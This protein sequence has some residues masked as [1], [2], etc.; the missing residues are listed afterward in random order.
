M[1]DGKATL[2]TVGGC[3]AGIIIIV[4]YTIIW[5]SNTTQTFNW[6]TTMAEEEGQP[7]VSL[8]FA[9]RRQWRFSRCCFLD[10]I[11]DLCVEFVPDATWPW[12]SQCYFVIFPLTKPINFVP[13]KNFHHF[14]ITL[15][16][17]F[18]LASWGNWTPCRWRI[19]RHCLGNWA[20]R[21]CDFRPSQC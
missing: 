15:A 12:Y 6:T 4:Y 20:Q 10:V 21:M 8:S 1:L 17:H 3:V 19:W 7:K 11:S 5:K 9:L 2:C 18:W 14:T 13:C 16:A